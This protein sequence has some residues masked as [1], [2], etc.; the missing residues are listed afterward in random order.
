MSKEK[1]T[2]EVSGYAYTKVRDRFKDVI[3]PNKES[4]ELNT[5]PPEIILKEGYNTKS[6]IWNSEG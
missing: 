4:K 1:D 2:I 3:K 5:N 6:D